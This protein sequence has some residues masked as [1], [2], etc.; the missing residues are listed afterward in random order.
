VV[1][2]P[3]PL[4]PMPIGVQII[5]APGGKI[6]HYGWLTALERAG[7]VFRSPAERIIAH[8]GR[9]PDILTRTA[10]FGARNGLVSMSGRSTCMAIILSA[11]LRKP[12]P[13]APA[14]KPPVSAISSRQVPAMICNA[15]RHRLQRNRHRDHRQADEGN[16]LVWMPILGR[17]GISTP[18]STKVACFRVFGA[19]QG[20]AGA[21][22]HVD[23]FEDLQHL[24]AV[25]AA[26]F[27]ARSTR[28]SGIIAPAS[29]GRAPRIEIVRSLAQAIEMQRAP[30]RW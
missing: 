13:R 5:A 3:V 1:A 27:C 23:D 2:V 9:F 15:D 25:P 26:D 18:S 11:G 21:D 29:S 22:D 30:Q 6:S 24:G 17:T 10:F 14:R 8:A 7:A 4:E 19:T 12:R 28:G 20:V 16:R